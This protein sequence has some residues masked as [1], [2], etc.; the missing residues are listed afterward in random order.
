VNDNLKN[1]DPNGITTFQ[2]SSLPSDWEVLSSQRPIVFV[3][4]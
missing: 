2:S 1:Y 4:F 3:V